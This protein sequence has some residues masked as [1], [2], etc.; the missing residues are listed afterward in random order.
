MTT[1]TILGLGEAG[2]LYA[3]GLRDAGAQVRGYDPFP[4]AEGT[5]I[6]RLEVLGEALAGA[7]VVVSLVGAVAAPIVAADA[8][9]MIAPSAVYADFNTAAPEVKQEIATLAA[10]RGVLMADVAILAPVPRAA[11]RTDLL[12][13]GTGAAALAERLSP[14]GVPLVVIGGDAGEAARLKLLRSMFMKG[15]AALVIEGVGAAGAVG[16]EQWVRDQMAGELGPDGR[17]LVDRLIDGTYRHS[18]RREHE[19]R[20]AL[21]MLEAWGRPADMTRATLAWFERINSEG[22]GASEPHR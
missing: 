22:A 6:P 8:L 2:R 15:L 1:V 17:E 16:A 11:H 7:D 14:F 9:A 21:S 12:A 3:R 20:D 13:S 4:Q 5:G 18:V 19:V 10:A